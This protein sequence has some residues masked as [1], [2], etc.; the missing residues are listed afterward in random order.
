MDFRNVFK[1]V[2]PI[3]I[4]IF[5]VNTHIINTSLPSEFSPTFLFSDSYILPLPVA[6]TYCNADSIGHDPLFC[7]SYIIQRICNISMVSVYPL[8]LA[9]FSFIHQISFLLHPRYDNV[10]SLLHHGLE[11]YNKHIHYQNEI[12]N[13]LSFL[14][15]RILL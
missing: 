11:M 14:Q 15:I 2:I 8:P 10:L 6:C 1:S 13:Y 7:L 3:F 9:E 12:S 5:F 4:F